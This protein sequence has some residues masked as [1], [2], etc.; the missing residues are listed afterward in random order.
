MFLLFLLVILVYWAYIEESTKEATQEWL[1]G[2]LS[3]GLATAPTNNVSIVWGNAN[4]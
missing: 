3:K 4:C 1:N 2:S